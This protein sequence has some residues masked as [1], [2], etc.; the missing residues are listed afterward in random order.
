MIIDATSQ[1]LGREASLVAKKALLGEKIDVVNCEKAVI[2]GTRKVVV[3]KY[4][5]KTQRGDPFHGPYISRTPHMLFRRTIRGMLPHK[6]DKGLKAYKRVKCHV[7][8]PEE[9]KTSKMETVKGA[10]VSKMPH[11]RY[12][13]MGELSHLIGGRL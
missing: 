3:T 5:Q 2:T 11:L 4:K 13:T 1:V 8:V 12:I 10:D 9:F 7:G 6:Q